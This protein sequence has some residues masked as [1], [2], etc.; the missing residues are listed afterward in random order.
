MHQGV[1]VVFDGAYAAGL[2]SGAKL[3]CGK[4]A[5]LKLRVG[6]GS[7]Q[8]VA[9]GAQPRMRLMQCGTCSAVACVGWFPQIC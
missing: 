9:V 4:D 1:C 2:L 6:A 3:A 8:E 5:A 7:R